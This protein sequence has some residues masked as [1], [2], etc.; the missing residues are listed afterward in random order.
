MQDIIIIGGGLSGLVNS[1]CLSRA[2]LTVT[3]IEKKSYPFHRVCGE[4]I[5]NEVLPFLNSIDVDIQ[6]LN[7]SKIN[8]LKVTSPLGAEINTILDLGG[9]GVSRFTLDNYL[10]QLA[11]KYGVTFLLNTQVQ[12]VIYQKDQFRVLAGNSE[13]LNSKIVIG[14]FGKRSNL[15]RHMNRSF[16]YKR[17]PYV[18]VKYHIKTDAPA[19]LISLHNFRDG[20][21]GM[22]MVEDQKF[23]LC[24]MTT[25]EN[26]KSAGDIPALENE[27]LSVNKNLDYIFKNSDF[28]YEK[29]EVINEISFSPKT[30][31]ENHVLMSGD[32]AGMITPLCG[33]GMAMAIHSTKILSE[34][35]I[36]HFPR[37][38]ESRTLLERE[39]S[40]Q[41]NK[42]FARRLMTGRIIQKLF[43]KEWLTEM[44]IRML[45]KSP[46]LTNK[47]VS[48]THGKEF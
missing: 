29:P 30:A 11:I 17:S 33:N 47:I 25:R 19:D 5:S 3:L 22:S 2:G 39:Y 14:S 10:F 42:L 12:D 27:I 13:D 1:I 36:K 8:R 9:F 15:D 35:I 43:G 23:C 45:G 34:L 41:W 24:Y 21:C 6:S 48:L 31:V 38:N 32:A 37:I 28:L 20:Y 26:L 46:G 4:Y 16:F 40:D 18:A 7:P 44:S